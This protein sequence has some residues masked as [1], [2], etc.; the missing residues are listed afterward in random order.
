MWTADFGMQISI[1]KKD[2]SN[3]QRVDWNLWLR[4]TDAP[5]SF[6]TWLNSDDLPA[7]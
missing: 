4:W 3:L 6:V 7:I 5:G 2:T 1:R